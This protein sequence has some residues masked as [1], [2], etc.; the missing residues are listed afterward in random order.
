MAFVS[1]PTIQILQYLLVIAG[2]F[3]SLYTA[4]RIAKHNYGAGKALAASMPYFIII[5][6][7][8]IATFLAFTVRM[9]LR[10]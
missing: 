9:G 1:D 7:F 4:Y 5:T 6:L 10:M 8:G 3:G 2:T